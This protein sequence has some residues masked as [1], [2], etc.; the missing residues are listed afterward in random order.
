[1][2]YKYKFSFENVRPAPDDINRVL[3]SSDV[4][5][6]TSLTDTVV[7]HVY[8]MV[9][10]SDEIA[11]GYR[12]VDCDSIDD[13]RGVIS[14]GG[15]ALEAGRR[16]SR[17]MNGASQLALF[18]CTAGA[19]F[20][21]ISHTYQSNNDFLEAFIV[22][23]IG[24][25][26]VEK[27]MDMIQERLRRDMAEQGLKITNRYS[28]GY[29]E[30]LLNGQK[31]LF[32]LIGMNSV[33]VTLSDSCLMQPIKSVSGIIGIGANVKLYPYGCRICA[34]KTCVYRKVLNNK[35]SNIK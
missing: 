14:C 2:F 5:C 34:S 7:N 24:S 4:D 12:L 3:Y 11:G 28:P 9:A 33:G 16:I 29:C 21:R 25:A 27:A 1:M 23:S 31:S 26:T 15:K 32:G 8:D 35:S 20:T 10:D 13:E 6:D 22:E 17:Y 18:V 30:W 19:L